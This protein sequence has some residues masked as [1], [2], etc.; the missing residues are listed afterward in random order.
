MVAI[1]DILRSVLLG[2]T[3]WKN[4]YRDGAGAWCTRIRIKA[5][6]FS[7]SFREYPE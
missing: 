3:F 1:M 4:K 6:T 2:F 5:K 7:A